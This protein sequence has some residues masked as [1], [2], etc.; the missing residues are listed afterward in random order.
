MDDAD[1]DA[2]ADHPGMLL[3]VRRL[4]GLD[5]WSRDGGLFH[6]DGCLAVSL[7]YR[8]MGCINIDIVFTVM[9]LVFLVPSLVSFVGNGLVQY[10][11]L[12]SVVCDNE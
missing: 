1:A 7:L 8:S 4:R 2:D 3:V 12:L 6:I 10:Y 9:L 5:R 11:V